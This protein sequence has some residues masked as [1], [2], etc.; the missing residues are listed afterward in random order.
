[1][2][3][4]RADRACS[5]RR[6]PP[7]PRRATRT[8]WSCSPMR[9]ASTNTTP[10]SA[11]VLDKLIAQRRRR[12]AG[13]SLHA[14]RRA[15]SGGRLAGGRAGP[16]AGA[17]ARAPTSPSVLNYLGYSWID[18]GVKLKDAKA[19]IEKAVAAKPQTPAR[20]SI[21][22]GWAY[23]RLGDYTDAVEQL[24]RGGGARAGRRRHQRPSRR[25]LLA[26]WGASIEA[27]FQW[28][29]VLV[30]RPAATSCAPRSRPSSEAGPGLRGPR[31]RL[32]ER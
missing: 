1:M 22:S 5:S 16:E 15:R 11:Q 8:R 21:P 2:P 29:Q 3:E 9:F 32:A 19:M 12:R 4:R 17:G 10:K 23:Y 27:R 6:R 31:L 25:R 18:R 26:R 13:A 28:E 24:E 14:R 20:S 7:R 30:A